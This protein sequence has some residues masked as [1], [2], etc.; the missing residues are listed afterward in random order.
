MLRNFVT[1][2]DLQKYYPKISGSLWAGSADYQN[3][4]DT[5]FEN[6]TLDLWNRGINPREVMLPISLKASGLE[7]TST[8]GES[9]PVFNHRRWNITVSSFTGSVEISLEGSHDQQNWSF[10]E[11]AMVVSG[12]AL[13]EYS[14][15]VS[16]QYKYY[17]YNSTIAGNCNYSVDLY[18][19]VFDNAIAQGAFKIIFRDFMKEKGD[20]W[21]VRRELVEKDYESTLNSIKFFYDS[22]DSG[23]TEEKEARQTINITLVR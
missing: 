9:V 22:D 7:A 17:R 20:I 19:T 5:A 12:S 16:G 8:V 1:D 11:K 2:S 13:G 4:I 15:V 10:V 6:L 23:T 3:Q 18:E 21:D 14:L